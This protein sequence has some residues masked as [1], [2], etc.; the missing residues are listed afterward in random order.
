MGLF[1]KGLS[2]HQTAL[3]MIGARPGDRVLV[4]GRPVPHVVAE[5]ARTTG[6]SGQTLLAVAPGV[7]SSYERAAGEAGVLVEMWEASGVEV[8]VPS[9]GQQHDLVVLHF[10]LG[11]LGE[12]ELARLV[13]S[14]F[15]AVRPSGRLVVVEGRPPASWF[16][17]RVATL[18][19]ERVLAI[20]AEGGGVA[21]RTLGSE[22]GITYF[23]ARKPR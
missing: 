17:R 20:L 22:P 1:R 7:R 18:P 9:T 2:P 21:A 11:R 5:L 19:A 6:L 3:A 14:A 8:L 13:E 12:G 10:D 16:E 15:A 23:E 4:A